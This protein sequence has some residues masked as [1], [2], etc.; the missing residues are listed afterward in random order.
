MWISNN[1]KNYSNML[2]NRNGC[3]R[4]FQIKETGGINYPLSLHWRR[5]TE[6]DIKWSQP[7]VTAPGNE[8]LELTMIQQSTLLHFMSVS[9]LRLLCKEWGKIIP[10]FKYHYYQSLL[11]R[12]AKIYTIRNANKKVLFEQNCTCFHN[13]KILM[14]K[15]TVTLRLFCE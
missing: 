15:S 8:Y 14:M 9:V 6:T 13:R 11:I 5:N 12:L 1:Q 3:K 7:Y 10:L 4:M 2:K